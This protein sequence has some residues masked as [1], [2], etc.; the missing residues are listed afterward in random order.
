[1]VEM[2]WSWNDYLE[3]PMDLV[4]EISARLDGRGRAEKEERRKAEATR[5]RRS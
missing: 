5:G 1:M 4:D 3:A 2:G